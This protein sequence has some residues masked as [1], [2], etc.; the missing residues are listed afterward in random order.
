MQG[1][2]KES[3][4]DK[5]WERRCKLQGRIERRSKMI[6]NVEELL[7]TKG[8]SSMK[9]TSDMLEEVKR[10][11]GEMDKL[12]REIRRVDEKVRYAEAAEDAEKKR[13]KARR[14]EAERIAKKEE[15]ERERERMRDEYWD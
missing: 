1:R 9:E 11:N 6:E 2:G 14:E 13:E 5:Q 15:Q 3:E 12:R 10:V 7:K 8:M 4:A